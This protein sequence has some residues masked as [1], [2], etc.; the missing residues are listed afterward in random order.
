[1]R[2]SRTRPTALAAAVAVI[3]L[4]AAGTSPAPAA[5]AARR[6]KP[7]TL[8][9]K[10]LSPLSI[11]IAPNGTIYL[12]ENFA[13]RLIKKPPRKG[14]LSIHP[15][16]KG[17]DVGGVSVSGSSVIVTVTPGSGMAQV[18]K[19]TQ[20][21]RITTLANTGKYEKAQ[22]PDA[23][24]TYGFRDIGMECAAQF[25]DGTQTNYTGIVDSHPYATDT[26]KGTTY[27]ADAAGNAILAL[28]KGTLSTVA[29]LP[30]I[31]VVFTSEMA[32]ANGYPD[33][34]AGLT[35]WLEPVPTDVE[36]GP[37]GLLYVS[38]LPGGPED[39]SLGA[40]G[41]VFVVDPGSGAVT[42]LVNGL[43]SAVNLAVAKNG[44]VYVAQ[45]LA[46]RISRIPAGTNTVQPFKTV[47]Q[48]GA[49]EWTK[50]ALFATVNV[51]SG[52]SGGDDDAPR[53]KL[54]SFSL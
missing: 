16:S 42:L 11:A 9:T 38:S 23:S 5:P 22:N 49:I 18:K 37:D 4:V 39:G 31:P 17:S 50:K 54:V 25:P 12:T 27:I 48:P 36:Q 33:C 26:V 34:V 51:L 43:M 10:L 3:G 15:G 6:A 47:F 8:A 52:T 21:G 46:N 28:K 30:A 24:T 13:S 20:A 44:D 19:V 1:V 41:G 35:Y 32:A 29:V 53:G 2:T 14:A 45:M 40:L 7:V